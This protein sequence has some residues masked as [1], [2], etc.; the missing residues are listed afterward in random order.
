[1]AKKVIPNCVEVRLHWLF[2]SVIGFNVL[3]G[4]KGTTAVNQAL[5]D[6]LFTT[7]GPQLSS[8][9]LAAVMHTTSAFQHIGVRDI[10][11]ADQPEFVSAGTAVAGTGTGNALP[12][13]IAL[14]ATFRSAQVGRSNRGRAYQGGF[15]DD[16]TLTSGRATPATTAAVEGFWS[17]VRATLNAQGLVHCIGQIALPQ[18][19]NAAGETLPARA[20]NA[21][22]VTT[23]VVVL[24]NVFD[25]V[26]RRKT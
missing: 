7:L 18:R 21:N 19:T 20:A 5:A 25:T 16:A 3:H 10:S 6:N 22:V 8:S 23:S 13:Q 26:R 14:V 1:M 12:P 4:Q 11:V 15:S 17:S 24:D 9:G 2:G